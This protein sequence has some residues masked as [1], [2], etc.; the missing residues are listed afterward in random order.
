VMVRPVRNP[1]CTTL[2]AASVA[3]IGWFNTSVT[4]LG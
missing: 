2:L 4:I 1:I 3:R